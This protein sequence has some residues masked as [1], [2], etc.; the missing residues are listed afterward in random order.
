MK[1]IYRIHPI[2]NGIAEII[3]T[4]TKVRIHLG[5]ESECAAYAERFGLQVIA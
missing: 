1:A 5:T 4:T 3:E 2:I